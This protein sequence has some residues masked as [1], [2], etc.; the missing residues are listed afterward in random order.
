[1]TQ[2]G[3]EA[4]YTYDANGNLTQGHGRSLTWNAANQPTSVTGSDG[5]Q[6][7]TPTTPMA[8]VGAGPARV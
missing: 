1:M 5:V 3:I 6:E 7:T 4:A 2:T 8:S